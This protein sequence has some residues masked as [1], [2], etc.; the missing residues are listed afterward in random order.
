MSIRVRALSLRETLRM[1]LWFIPTVA[2]AAAVALASASIALDHRVPQARDWPLLFPGGPES[3]RNLLSTIAAAV[4]TSISLIFSVTM[5]V[6]QLASA[7][8]SPRVL[9]TFLRDRLVQTVL[10]VYIA[11]F[12]Y[13]LIVL[14][15]VT[16]P[17]GREEAFVPAVS[18][19]TAVVLAL[20]SL[21]L[22]VRYIHH[23]A[24]SIRASSVLKSVADETR[25]AL[26]VLYPEKLGDDAPR[27][28]AEPMERPTEVVPADRLGV[29]VAIDEE[30]LLRVAVECDVVVRVITLVGEF[31]P[32]G[33]PLFHIWERGSAIDTREFIECVAFDDER[34]IEQ[35]AAFG[36]RQI[37]DIA[38]RALSPGVNDPTTATQA[39][40]QLRDLLRRLVGRQFPSPRRVD[41]DGGLRVIVPRLAWDDYVALAFEEIRLYAGKSVLVLRRLRGAIVDLL[42]VAPPSRRAPLEQQLRLVESA[43]RREMDDSSDQAR[44][45]EGANLS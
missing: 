9:R 17:D 13:C 2:V 21:A 35:D 19:S 6:L 10:G 15:S 42:D 4:V 30:R 31:I 29:V 41:A 33:A 24:H 7:Q 43:A 34:T 32:E 20:M 28:V 18:V 23:I 22:F 5:V 8:Y 3:A 1:S 39:I 27:E 14:P 40:D 38:A 37:V 44:A 25:A 36:F 12:V 45:H 26:D 11:T 16:S